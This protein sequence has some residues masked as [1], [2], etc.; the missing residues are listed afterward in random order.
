MIYNTVIYRNNLVGFAEAASNQPCGTRFSPDACRAVSCP[1]CATC[2]HYP[3]RTWRMPVAGSP[4]PGHSAAGRA[5]LRPQPPHHGRMCR[6]LWTCRENQSSSLLFAFSCRAERSFRILHIPVEQLAVTTVQA[7]ICL[8]AV[9]ADQIC[10]RSCHDRYFLL[11][12][13]ISL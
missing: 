7:V 5:A 9:C 1:V 11:N 6:R 13:R 3:V 2:P 10:L 12:S 4:S 8:V